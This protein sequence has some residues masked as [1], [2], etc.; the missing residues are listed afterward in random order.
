MTLAIKRSVLVSL[1]I[2]STYTGDGFGET[3]GHRCRVTRTCRAAD[4]PDVPLS[5]RPHQDLS[6][7]QM[8]ALHYQSA[9]AAM[10]GAE[11]DDW[12]SH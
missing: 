9:D 4:H 2:W 5:A 8:N 11:G 12:R 1:G 7:P 10:K 3:H 6:Q